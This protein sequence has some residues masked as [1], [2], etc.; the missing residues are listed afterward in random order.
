MFRD[1]EYLSTMRRYLS[2]ARDSHNH[3]SIDLINVLPPGQDQNG[4]A[5]LDISAVSLLSVE[6]KKQ[7]VQYDLKELL[8]GLAKHL[9]G[10]NI[11]MKWR[12][13]YFPFTEPSFELDILFLK[14]GESPPAATTTAEEE[15]EKWLEVLGCGVV[16]DDVMGVCRDRAAAANLTIG[17][18]GWAFGLG[19]ERLAMVLFSIPDIRLFWSLDVRFLS[20]FSGDKITKFAP[21]SKFPLCYKDVSFWLPLPQVG[22]AS[23][24][25]DN[26]EKIK[27]TE[28]HPNEVFEVRVA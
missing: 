23:T 8:F 6:Q 1:E 24:L 14:D 13:D 3:D 21:F 22:E 19:L 4:T 5:E 11:T 12:E 28:F 7:L 20:Q 16:H 18:H 2:A 17:E 9:F 25:P 10:P 26:G 15:D 27:M